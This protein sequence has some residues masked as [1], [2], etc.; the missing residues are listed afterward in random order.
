MTNK[1]IL[2]W[3]SLL[4]VFSLNHAQALQLRHAE[5]II[6]KTGVSFKD[7]KS[8]DAVLTDVDVDS[9][10]IVE[11]SLYAKD[12]NH[13]YYRNNILDK[14]DPATTEYIGNHAIKDKHRLYLY[15]TEIKGIDA[16]SY[17]Q[18]S[19]S[20][21]GKDKY[22]LFFNF[23]PVLD[24]DVDSFVVL[25]SETQAVWFGGNYSSN[26]YGKDK[27]SAYYEGKK[28]ANVDLASFKALFNGY[29]KDSKFVYYNG[30]IVNGANPK[31]FVPPSLSRPDL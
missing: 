22:S 20:R 12:K 30:E 8:V 4:M 7:Y 3:G 26:C 15:G 5:Y 28:M 16:E 29:A 25:D 17:Q 14:L 21:Y 31:T 24:V 10:V 2:L 23:E 19:G 1:S 11:P 27:N 9:F 6:G 18:L 13:V